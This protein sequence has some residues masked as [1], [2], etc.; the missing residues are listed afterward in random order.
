MKFLAD[1]FPV[2]LFFIAYKLYG[3]YVATAAAIV[4]S[5]IQVSVHWFHHHKLEKMHVITLVL[6]VVFGG[7][8]I[9]L[10]DRAFIMWKPSILN[11]LFALVFL[12]SHF[13]GDK[14]LIQRMMGHAIEIPGSI[15]ARLNRM[16]VLFFIASGAANLYVANRYFM[17][18]DKLRALSGTLEVNIDDCPGNFTDQA[19]S[20]C[21]EAV[22]REETWVNFKLFGMMGLTIVFV[23]LQAFYMARHVKDEE[24]QREN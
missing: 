11:W 12:G 22:Q 3:I 21:L 5:V 19:L 23:L 16:W 24:P 6:L 20:L 14:P 9:I 10:Q 7:L 2:I 15:W 18:E 1:F 17:V 8:T 13:I 4:A